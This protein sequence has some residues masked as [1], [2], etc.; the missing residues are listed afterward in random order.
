MIYNIIRAGV[1]VYGVIRDSDV[2][3]RMNV[4]IRALGTS[5]VKS[6]KR[7]WGVENISIQFDHGTTITPG[8]WIYA[9]AD[10]ILVSKTQLI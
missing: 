9:D 4:S 6:I 10:G 3:N 2:I 5:P 8:D 1:V 7:E